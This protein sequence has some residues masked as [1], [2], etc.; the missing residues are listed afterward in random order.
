[1]SL[2]VPFH[3]KRLFTQMAVECREKWEVGVNTLY[4]QFQV[5]LQSEGLLTLSTLPLPFVGEEMSLFNMP[6][7]FF[8]SFKL[9]A[10]MRAMVLFNWFL[11]WVLGWQLMDLSHV[12]FE[13]HR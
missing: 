9:F 7:H 13:V 12:S 11:E 5:S 3:S 6:L 8:H 1:M 10:A 4:V 2:Q